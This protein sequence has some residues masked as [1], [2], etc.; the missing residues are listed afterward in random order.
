M[1]ST[2]VLWLLRLIHILSGVFW[3]GGFMVFARFVFPAALAVGPAAGTGLDQ[4]NSVRQRPRALLGAGTLTILS[5]L[6]LYWRDSVGSGSAWAGSPTGRVFGIG[7]LLA[8]RGVVV[9]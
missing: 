6:G 4:L 7:A 1:S 3:V 5:G 2:A 9:G 8:V